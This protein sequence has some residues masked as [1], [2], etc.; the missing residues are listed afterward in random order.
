MALQ[1]DERQGVFVLV[2]E[3]EVMTGDALRAQV[4]LQF[5]RKSENGFAEFI[6]PDFDVVQ[7]HRMAQALPGGFGEGFLGGEAFGE[8]ARGVRLLRV[9]GEFVRGQQAPREG[10]AVA[11]AGFS[12][13]HDADD[14]GAD[15]EDHGTSN[16]FIF[17]TACSSPMNTASEMMAWP[18][19]SSA[20]CGIATIGRTL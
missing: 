11:F 7:A 5:G 3:G 12:D 8:V 18:M 2:A 17:F 20:M 9:L 16:T 1:D 14:V 10:G 19:L 15:A 6:V 4:L 13:A